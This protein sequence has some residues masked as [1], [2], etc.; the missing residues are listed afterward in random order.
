MVDLQHVPAGDQRAWSVSFGARTPVEIIAGL[1][2]ALTGPAAAAL[3]P[4]P[5]P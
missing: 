2:D 1:T 3:T 5:D 4:A